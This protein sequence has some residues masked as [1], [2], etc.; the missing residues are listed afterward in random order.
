MNRRLLIGVTVAVILSVI[1]ALTY[2][3]Q[4]PSPT[5]VQAM[6]CP[7][8]VRGCSGAGLTV[9]MD[10]VPQVMRPF[11]LT[12][13]V[14]AMDAEKI[15]AMEVSFQMAGMEMGF[16]RY[17]LQQRGAG[18]W[19]AEVTL[20]VCVRDRKD[21]L[22]LLDVRQGQARREVAISFRTE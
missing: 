8:I 20:P 17:K 1:G 4:V 5:L 2:L 14:D 7:D 15:D 16:N 11:K 22:M 18:D 6:G 19:E 12:V 9:R 3:R 21:W 13:H 10:R